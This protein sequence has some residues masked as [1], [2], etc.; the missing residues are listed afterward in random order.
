MEAPNR[1]AEAWARNLRSGDEE[2]VPSSD[3]LVFGKPRE[4][5]RRKSQGPQS[6]VTRGL[7]P[8]PEGGG[9]VWDFER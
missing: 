6:G 4:K 8:K 1:E 2:D 3:P 9:K 5:V 7:H